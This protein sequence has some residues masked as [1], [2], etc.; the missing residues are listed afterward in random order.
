MNKIPTYA[1]NKVWHVGVMDQSLKQNGSLEGSGLSV[2][3]CPLAWEEIAELGGSY[4]ELIKES[5]TFLDFHELSDEQR[6]EITQWGLL[7]GFV[8]LETLYKY[9]MY[10]EEG[11]EMY[12]LVH[13]YEEALEEAMGDEECVI[14]APDS[15]VPTLKLVERVMG[16]S[17]VNA[18]HVLTTV[19]TEDVLG[20]DGVWFHDDLDRYALSAPRG[21]IA[22]NQLDSWSAKEIK[23]SEVPTWGSR[24]EE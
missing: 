2:S 14:E 3:E 24:Y 19:Y 9:V 5:G 7:N 18:F 4:F 23:E 17:L 10:D 13:T 8:T 20:L 11:E 22:V 6:Q 15:I 16:D 12:G 21:V 1:I